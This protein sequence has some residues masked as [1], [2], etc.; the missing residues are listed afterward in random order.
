MALNTCPI[1]YIRYCTIA[2]AQVLAASIM[3]RAKYFEG[4]C[5]LDEC[6]WQGSNDD[7]DFERKLLMHCEAHAHEDESEVD[8]TFDDDADDDNDDDSNN[9]FT[10]F[11]IGEGEQNDTTSDGNNVSNDTTSDVTNIVSTIHEEETGIEVIMQRL[12]E[13]CAMDVTDVLDF[14]SQCPFC[15]AAKNFEVNFEDDSSSLCL[16][17]SH[18]IADGDNDNRKE[19]NSV[20]LTASAPGGKSRAKGNHKDQLLKG[21]IATFLQENGRAQQTT[22]LP[23]T[24][25]TPESR[26]DTSPF[27]QPRANVEVSSSL[28]EWNVRI[29][30]LEKLY[31]DL[32]RLHHELDKFDA[33]LAAKSSTIGT[34][35]AHTTA[36]DFT[37]AMID[38]DTIDVRYQLFQIENYYSKQQRR[39]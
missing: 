38:V 10:M 25:L 13:T 31:S 35:Q 22:M 39:R 18:Y 3:L 21:M 7:D 24:S 4:K 37:H 17:G 16:D 20:L 26:D 11:E 5:L 28:R 34:T 32:H 15:M 30:P 9:S 2:K 36:H 14:D 1:N 29:E 23:E 12:C 6:S 8:T 27:T 33:S 19:L